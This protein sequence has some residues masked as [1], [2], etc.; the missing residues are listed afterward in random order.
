VG[1]APRDVL[2]LQ[3][4]RVGE[5]QAVAEDEAGQQALPRGLALCRAQDAAAILWGERQIMH[6]TM[7][8]AVRRDPS[9]C[10]G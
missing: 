7:F 2:D 8:A 10:C 5:R 3:R 9:P 4:Q 1:V 6:A